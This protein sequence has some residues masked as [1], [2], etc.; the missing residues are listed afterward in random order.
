MDI[1]VGGFSLWIRESKNRLMATWMYALMDMRE[2]TTATVSKA[3]MVVG[4]VGSRAPARVM[5]ANKAEE[6]E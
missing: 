3:T 2:R 1:W 6:V 4:S 5:M